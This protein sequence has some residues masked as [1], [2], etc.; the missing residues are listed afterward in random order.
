MPKNILSIGLE[1]DQRFGDID[2][3][4]VNMDRLIPANHTGR[5]I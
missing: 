1:E 3:V 2:P 5:E 4:Y